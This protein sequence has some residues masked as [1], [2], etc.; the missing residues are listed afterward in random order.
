[1]A[2]NPKLERFGVLVGEWDTVGT[3]RLLSGVTLHGHVTCEWIEGG[4]F[5]RMVSQMEKAGVPSGM[6]IF[7]SDD[8]SDAVTL[9]YY[10]E[11]GVSRIYAAALSGRIL[12]FWRNAPGPGL[13][14]R[15]TA[16]F[17][18][19]GRTI[20]FVSELSEDGTTWLIDIEQTYTRVR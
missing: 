2:V 8:A 6:F 9:L 10:D 1:M 15:F 14:Q 11:R 17:A 18:E 7:G 12:K 19:D 4:A 3:H 13:A 16:T 5:L 20:Q